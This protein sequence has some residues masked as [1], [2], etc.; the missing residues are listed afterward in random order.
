MIGSLKAIKVKSIE[1]DPFDG[2]PFM[3][4]A[5]GRVGAILLRFGLPLSPKRVLPKLFNRMV[6]VLFLSAWVERVRCIMAYRHRM[7][8]L[9]PL[10]MAR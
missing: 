3:M 8:L 5:L 6:G 9:M 4:M 7:V 1:S 10:L 2:I